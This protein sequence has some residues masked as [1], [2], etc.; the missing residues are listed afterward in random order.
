MREDEIHN[1]LKACHDEPCGGHFA[2]KRISH[3]EIR[4]GYFF[5][6]MFQDTKKYSQACENIQ[7]MGQP[8]K[9]DEMLLHPQLVVEPF[10][11]WDLEF[12]GLTNPPSR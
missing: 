10:D 11:K 9:L 2:N 8:N 5:P 12:V 7:R 4:M 3:K 6:T 1:I